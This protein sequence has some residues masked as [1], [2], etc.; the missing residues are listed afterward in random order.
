MT[1]PRVGY[2]DS[3]DD[4]VTSYPVPS[5]AVG[6]RQ[7]NDLLAASWCTNAWVRDETGTVVWSLEMD[8][9]PPKDQSPMSADE[10]DVLRLEEAE[11]RGN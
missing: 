8:S 2:V 1:A 3:R 10:A 11:R 7:A 6:V 5:V 4:S 9:L